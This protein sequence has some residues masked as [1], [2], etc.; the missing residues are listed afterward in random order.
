LTENQNLQTL[1]LEDAGRDLA[2][3]GI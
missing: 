2:L 1:H 3:I